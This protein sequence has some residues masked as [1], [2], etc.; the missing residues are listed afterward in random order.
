LCEQITLRFYCTQGTPIHHDFTMCTV[1]TKCVYI[2]HHIS[3]K[4]LYAPTTYHQH[5]NARTHTPFNNRYIPTLLYNIRSRLPQ[6]MAPLNRTTLTRSKTLASSRKSTAPRPIR[7]SRITKPTIPSTSHLH[8]T[9]LRR[10]ALVSMEADEASSSSDGE[11]SDEGEDIDLGL[12][13]LRKRKRGW[14]SMRRMGS[15]GWW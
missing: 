13:I 5:I 8:R 10:A 2:Y 3:C 12:M 15:C 1:T 14:M 9:E 6:S 7:T 4:M 11:P